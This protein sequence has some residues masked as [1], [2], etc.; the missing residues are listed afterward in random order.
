MKIF[1]LFLCFERILS[2][3]FETGIRSVLHSHAFANTIFKEISFY[4]IDN[5][6]TV[7]KVSSNIQDILVE[8]IYLSLILGSF[9]G[10]WLY[11]SPQSSLNK[12]ENVHDY[13]LLKKRMNSVF[14]FMMVLIMKN[15]DNVI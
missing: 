5:P 13:R 3:R 10:N 12:L 6:L 11:D 1:F 14:I 2:F 15:I 4:Y 7:Y 8:T 9:W